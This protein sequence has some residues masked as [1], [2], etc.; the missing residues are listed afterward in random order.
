M[1]SSISFVDVVLSGILSANFT[2][3]DFSTSNASISFSCLIPKLP[4][5]I[6]TK[7]LSSFLF[8]RF[9]TSAVYS[10]SWP[11]VTFCGPFTSLITIIF[12][13]SSIVIVACL[14]GEVALRL[15]QML[16]LSGSNIFAY[17]KY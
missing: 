3:F 2:V 11:A 6:T 16:S 14:S 17:K 15:V 10:A 1:N 12:S 8:P 7:I 13:S 4:L 9:I 5:Y